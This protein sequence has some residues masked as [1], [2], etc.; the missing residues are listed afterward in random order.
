MLI[1]KVSE[2]TNLQRGSF[3]VGAELTL[4]IAGTISG[5]NDVAG[6][7]GNGGSP[8]PAFSLPGE[9]QPGGAGGKAIAGIANVDPS[10]FTGSIIGTTS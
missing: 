9:A 8:T 6:T 1:E 2:V 4:K 7:G 5:A 3:P 10:E